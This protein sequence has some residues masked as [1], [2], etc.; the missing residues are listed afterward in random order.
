MR[1]WHGPHPEE[2]RSAVSKDEAAAGYPPALSSDPSWT[3]SSSDEDT[4]GTCSPSEARATTP[5]VLL[6][7]ASAPA[8]GIEVVEQLGHQHAVLA[9][10]IV[11]HLA[12]RRRRQDQR[13]VGR[14]DR[15]EAVGE[16]AE[17]ALIG[18]APRGVDDDELGAGA[19]LVHRRQAPDSTL[20]PVAADVGCLPDR[21][22]RPGSCSS[23]GR[24]GRHSRRRTASPRNWAGSSI[25]AGR[26]RGSCRP[27]WHPPP[28][29]RR[30]RR[31]AAP[32]V[33]AL[34]SLIGW[35]SGALA[36]G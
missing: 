10:G 19:A 27:C 18:I 3:S 23:R 15:R 7:A 8:R 20:M 13:I 22:H 30:N 29:R 2:A 21:R 16:G 1:V 14:V 9:A 34:A 33:S 11:D 6:K 12:R 5:R 28:R 31:A 24:P 4:D 32:R 25:S 26:P 17:A 36:S 35:V